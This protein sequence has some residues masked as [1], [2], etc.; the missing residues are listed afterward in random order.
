MAQTFKLPYWCKNCG[1]GSVAVCFEP[2]MK[3]AHNAE[4]EEDEEYGEGWG[5]PSVSSVEIKVEDGKL[6]FKDYDGWKEVEQ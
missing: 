6:F 4:N 2:S 5:E 3:A 1:D